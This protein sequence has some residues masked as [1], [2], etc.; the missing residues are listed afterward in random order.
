MNPQTLDDLEWLEQYYA[1]NCDGD[2]EH[3][4]GFRIDNIDNPGWS[5]EF[6]L[7]GTPLSG[8]DFRAVSVDRTESDWVRCEVKNEKFIAYGG[9]TNL[10]ELISIFRSWA[11]ELIAMA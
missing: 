8:H 5:L 11:E 9:A 1:Q 4:F 10:T 6:D 2:W 3:S 7:K